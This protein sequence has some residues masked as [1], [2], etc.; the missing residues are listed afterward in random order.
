MNLETRLQLSYYRQIGVI[1]EAHR[2]Y[3]VQHIETGKIFVKKIMTAYNPEVYARLKEH[4]VPGTPAIVCLHEENDELTL[5]EEY[6]SGDTL[7]E[8][9]ENG[10]MSEF[11]VLNYGLMLCN[12]VERL[13]RLTP[14]VIH[15]DIKPSNIIITKDHRVVLI[16]LNA[17]RAGISKEEDTVLLGTKGYAAPEQFGFGSSGVT[18]DI[19]A[20]GMVLNTM[21]LGSFS[22]EVIQRSSLTGVIRRCT[23]INPKDRYSDI[24]ELKEM[25]RRILVDIAPPPQ[26]QTRN[27]TRAH[28]PVKIKL[29]R[30]DFLPPGFRTGSVPNMFLAAVGYLL[31]GILSLTFTSPGSTPGMILTIKI[32]MILIGLGGVVC[33][34]NYLGVCERFPYAMDRNPLIRAL[35]RTAEFV[36]YAVVVVFTA[37]LISVSFT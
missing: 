12:I 13:H 3:L 6:I 5:I 7:E 33:Y 23:E 2:V 1:N 30:K 18:T 8:V 36:I 21:L 4:Y 11:T 16:D 37:A 35:A 24:A 31:I 14:P 27:N 34:F 19:Y 10:P 28:S 9:L 17:A 32:L 15:R 22:K 25:L 29:S 26:G 20:I